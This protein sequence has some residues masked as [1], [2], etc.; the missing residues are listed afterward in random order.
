MPAIRRR[1]ET[2]WNCLEVLDAKIVS[3]F[4]KTVCGFCGTRIR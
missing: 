1:P 3:P 4:L 2:D